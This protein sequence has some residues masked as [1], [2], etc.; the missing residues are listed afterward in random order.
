MYSLSILSAL[1]S[2]ATV[3]SSIDA[4]SSTRPFSECSHAEFRRKEHASLSLHVFLP[5]DDNTHE[6]EGDANNDDDDAFDVEKA[7][8]RFEALVG[9]TK[10]ESF[11]ATTSSKQ[12]FERLPNF[13]NNKNKIRSATIYNNP[14]PL[15]ALDVVLPPAN[16]LTTIERERRQVEI[17]LLAQLAEGD[18]TVTDIWTLWFGERGSEAAKKLVRAEELTN[19]S[20][21]LW[22]QAEDILRDLIQE[23]GVYWVEPLNRLSTLYYMQGR[24]DEAETL[25]KIVLAVKPWHFGALSGIVMVYAAQADSEKA[26]M[27]AASRLP[28]FA[29]TGPNRRRIAWAETAVASAQES[30]DI[31]EKRVQELFGPPDDYIIKKEQLDMWGTDAWQ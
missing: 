8:K 18:E 11:K 25:C 9:N 6:D 29:P 22:K 31:A 5:R 24:L 20:P 10:E 1:V 7:R 17:Q 14:S 3:L 15:P 28:T 2:A 13:G 21:T 12:T 30:L 26:R 23:Y 27:W 4:F 19:E 16:P